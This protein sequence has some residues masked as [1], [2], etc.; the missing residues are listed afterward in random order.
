MEAYFAFSD[1]CGA[2][3]KTRS[4]RFV[5]THPY[6]VRATVIMSFADYRALE[7]EL[8]AIKASFGLAQNVEVKWSHYG[9]ALKDNYSKIPHQLTASQLHDY[10]EQVL[11]R[12]KEHPSICIYYTITENKTVAAIEETLLLKWHLQNAMQRVQS[13]MASVNGFAIIV[14]DDLNEKT[15]ELKQA[16][17]DMTREGDFVNYTHIK[18][19]LYVDYSNQCC[20]LQVADLCAG[21]FTASLKWLSAT[22]QDKKKYAMGYNL[23]CSSVYAKIRYSDFHLPYYSV[24]RFGVKE[25][26]QGIGESIAKKISHKASDLLERDLQQLLW[27]DD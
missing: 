7:L 23:F 1:E 24:Y 25:V 10:Y 8:N 4:S 27:G 6:Y 22:E 19:G 16:V 11:A 2:Y 14:A 3:Q 18:Q 20:G 9:S 15:K 21:V 12:I 5:T 26:P 17:Y 13:T